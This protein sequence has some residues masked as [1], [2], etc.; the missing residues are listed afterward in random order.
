LQVQTHQFVLVEAQSV[1]TNDSMTLHMSLEEVRSESCNY[2]VDLPIGDPAS[3]EYASIYMLDPL[4]VHRFN[5]LHIK[6]YV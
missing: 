2:M 3:A 6:S 4:P 5:G 1:W